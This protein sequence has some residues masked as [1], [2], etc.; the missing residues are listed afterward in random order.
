MLNYYITQCTG[1][2]IS[3]RQDAVEK[4]EGALRLPIESLEIRPVGEKMLD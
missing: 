4:A 2:S 1:N 3:L